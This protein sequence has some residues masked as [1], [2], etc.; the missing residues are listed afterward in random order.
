MNTKNIT[1]ETNWVRVIGNTRSPHCNQM[2]EMIW[3]ECEVHYSHHES[4]TIRIWNKNKSD[5]WTFNKKDV[6]FLTP[7]M[8][9]EKHIA[10]DDEVKFIGEWRKVLGFYVYDN[11]VKITIGTLE[12]TFNCSEENIQDHRTE[13]L[14]LK[15]NF[16]DQSDETKTFIERLLK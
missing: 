8:F 6:R 14:S 13:K 12:D 9:N 1:I 5:Y 11:R 2:N 3:E 10:I 4:D 7:A 15:D 16:N